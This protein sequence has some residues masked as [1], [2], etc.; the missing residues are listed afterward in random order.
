MNIRLITF[1]LLIFLFQANL[2]KANEK[3]TPKKKT[4]HEFK[5]RDG[6]PNF[7]T[8]AFRGNP[9]TVAYL[10]GSITAQNGWRVYSLEWFKHRFPQATFA[11]INAAIGG[12]GS[13]FGVFRLQ[14]QILNYKPDLVFVEFAVND[15][16]EKKEEIIRST[17]S[18]VRK[19]WEQNPKIDICFIYTLSEQFVDVLEKQQLP[20]SVQAMEEVATHYGIPSINYEIEVFKRLQDHSL[21]LKNKEK[22]IDGVTV[23][24]PDGVHPFV[25]TGH[26]IYFDI[27]KRSFERMDQCQKNQSHKLIKPLCPNFLANAQMIDPDKFLLSGNWSMLDTTDTGV[28]RFRKLISKVAKSHQTGATLCLKFKG[29]AIGFCDIMGPDAGRVILEVDGSLK[30]T[31]SR[32]DRYC[33]YHRINNYVIDNLKDTIHS[34]IFRVLADTFDKSN[35]LKAGGKEMIHQEDYKINNWCVGKILIDGRLIP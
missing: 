22:Q 13:K 31:I 11:E 34:V 19:I 23:F 8:K 15:G 5:E 2:L 35:I 29:Q 26:V 33:T 3:I 14:E 27:L 30:D 32:F 12:T 28:Y 18:I 21:I 7:F 24:S 9:I 10:G 25:E 17:E 6:L 4:L 1:C 20:E 16:S